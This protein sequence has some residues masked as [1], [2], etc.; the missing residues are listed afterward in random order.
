MDAVSHKA[1]SQDTNC[2]MWRVQCRG[3]PV[4]SG[5][6]SQVQCLEEQC[7]ILH[8]FLSVLRGFSVP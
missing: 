4:A 8:L 1:L 7:L 6:Q 2:P 3:V 5:V